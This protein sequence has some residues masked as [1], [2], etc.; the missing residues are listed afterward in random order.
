MR[1]RMGWLLVLS[2]AAG[3]IHAPHARAETPDPPPADASH[4]TDSSSVDA[5]RVRAQEHFDRA[6]QLRDAHS[7]DGALV[8][9]RAAYGSFPSPKILYNQAEVECELGLYVAA[10]DD[11][12]AF[13]REFVHADSEDDAR[14][15]ETA[16][17][18]AQKARARIAIIEPDAE[19]GVELVVD[20]RSVGTTPLAQPI[21]VDPGH[22]RVLF[23][24]AGL[25]D[26]SVD[27]VLATGQR[28][29][30]APHPLAAPSIATPAPEPERRKSLLRRWPFWVVVAGVAILGG[31]AA[32]YAVVHGSR[33]PCPPDVFC[34]PGD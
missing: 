10:I 18:A 2:V 32:T 11:Y 16:R 30:V 14:R 28:L 26:S 34:T 5:A 33:V 25:L 22:H 19:P 24:R 21:R 4:D 1:W 31:A 23:R 3:A 7:Y 9:F 6:N 15:I 20:A 17:E 13:L 27:I 12:D 8:E 29:H